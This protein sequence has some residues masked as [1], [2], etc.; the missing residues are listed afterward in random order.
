VRIL[1]KIDIL[2][3]N[4]TPM[5]TLE[6][7]LLSV[8]VGHFKG[9]ANLQDHPPKT[10]MNPALVTCPHDRSGANLS[11]MTDHYDPSLGKRISI[12]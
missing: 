4:V 1:L 6:R 12:F 2:D 7:S 5:T 10:S 3:Q 11:Q 8:F 9:R